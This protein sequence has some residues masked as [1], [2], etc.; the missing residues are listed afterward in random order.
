MRTSIL[1]ADAHSV[2]LAAE[3]LL[4]NNAGENACNLGKSVHSL[5]HREYT[6]SSVRCFLL[7]RFRCLLRSFMLHLH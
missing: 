3:R 1:Y 5:S 4:S 6:S 2:R 7:S